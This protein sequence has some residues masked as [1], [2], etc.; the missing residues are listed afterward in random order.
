MYVQVCLV[1]KYIQLHDIHIHTYIKSNVTSNTMLQY[2]YTYTQTSAWAE[3][4]V[5]GVLD[6]VWFSLRTYNFF[7]RTP[8]SF[9]RRSSTCNIFGNRFFGC[10]CVSLYMCAEVYS[11][12]SLE[13]SQVCVDREG[14]AGF[15]WAVDHSV[16]IGG[17]K[18]YT[19]GYQKK[20]RKLLDF[21][22]DQ[23]PYK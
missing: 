2:T 16:F 6:T 1:Y 11:T 14:S 22:L 18:G 3:I 23:S 5:H 17:G 13:V 12:T 19:W 9:S 4:F 8:G 20:I 15:T 7:E 10:V 21:L